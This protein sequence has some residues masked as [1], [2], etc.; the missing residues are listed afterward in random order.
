[1]N[2]AGVWL[3]GGHSFRWKSQ[4]ENYSVTIHKN[5]QRDLHLWDLVK[6][7]ASPSWSRTRAPASRQTELRWFLRGGER[8]KN[9]G[10]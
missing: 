1:M 9:T 7:Q 8:Y 10:Y 2:G 5:I 6:D 3:G 4:H